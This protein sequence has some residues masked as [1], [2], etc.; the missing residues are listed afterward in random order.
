[1]DYHERV[2]GSKEETYA[3][4]WPNSVLNSVSSSN[5]FAGTTENDAPSPPSRESCGPSPTTGVESVAGPSPAQGRLRAIPST[6]TCG[7]VFEDQDRLAHASLEETTRL[8]PLPLCDAIKRLPDPDDETNFVASVSMLFP[9]ETSEHSCQMEI[10]I[11]E[12][13]ID[14]LAWD[15]FGV[16]M[17]VTAGF[18]YL[19]GPGGTKILPNPKFAIRGCRH[20]VI[21]KEFGPEIAKAVTRSPA[22]MEE[23]KQCRGRTE[24]VWMVVS[25]N[26]EDSAQLCLSMDLTEGTLIRRKLYK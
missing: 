22:Y 1:M 8:I 19:C 16:K 25:Q 9:S 21:S 13:K 15:L 6:N 17:E 12:N 5:A 4:K 23:V 26:A 3:Y 14:H 2:T 11:L 18:R 7:L 20:D 24:C 10:E